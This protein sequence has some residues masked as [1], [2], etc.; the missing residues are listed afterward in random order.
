VVTGGDRRGLILSR[1]QPKPDGTGFL[2]GGGGWPRNTE[3]ASAALAWVAITCKHSQTTSVRRP[4]RL[5]TTSY[6]K[7][8]I[9]R[10]DGG[11]RLGIGRFSQKLIILNF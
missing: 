8:T 4:D 7:I 9:I 2:L 5:R 10:M 11:L 6:L 3:A 1:L